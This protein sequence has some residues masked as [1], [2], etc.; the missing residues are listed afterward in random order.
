MQYE[1]TESWME[2]NVARLRLSIRAVETMRLPQ[3]KGST[4]RG[5]FGHAFRSVSCGQPGQDCKVCLLRVGCP[6]AYVFATSPGQDAEVLRLNEEIPRP[7]VFEPPEDSRCVYAPGETMDFGLVLIGRGIEYLPYFIV[8]FQELGRNGMGTGRGRFELARVVACVAGQEHSVYD[9]TDGRIHWREAEC[10]VS[11]DQ[12]IASRPP[13]SGDLTVSFKTMT[14]LKDRGEYMTNPEFHPLLRALLRRIS[15]LSYFHCGT[16]LEADYQG[17]SARARSVALAANQ[18]TW[19]D[20]ER[21]SGRQKEWMSMGGLV[22][23][24]VYHGAWQE[25]WPWLALGEW[26]H[27]GKNATFGLGKY[28]IHKGL[29][30]NSGQEL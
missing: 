7:F 27:V 19:V 3:Y 18:T 8:T 28:V 6:F 13:Q 26:V 15:A 10:T 1:T 5:A 4:L 14:R 23:R 2:F 11:A 29:S 21:Y 22:G 24:A 25:F 12:I 17:L 20:W 16:R 30:A 9:D